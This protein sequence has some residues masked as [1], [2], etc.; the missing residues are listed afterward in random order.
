M[1]KKPQ[2]KQF[3]AHKNFSERK[4]GYFWLWCFLYAQ[5]LCVK[6]IDW[7]EI[8]LVNSFTIPLACT[9][10]NP[11]IENSFVHTYF[12]L[13]SSV[14]ISFFYENLFKYFFSVRVF[15]SCETLLKSV[16]FLWIYV[17]MKISQCM[18]PIIWSKSF[19]I[20]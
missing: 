8:V 4:I 7:L 13:R 5:N 15:S 17:F 1:N 19:I 12:Y 14:R 18:N 16:S 11:F 6:K 2:R 9:P 3:F 20:R 10:I